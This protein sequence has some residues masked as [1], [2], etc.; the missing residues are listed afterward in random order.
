MGKGHKVLETGEIKYTPSVPELNFEAFLDWSY[1][2]FM[3]PSCFFKAKAWKECGPLREDLYFCL[4]V[5]LW[6]KMSQKYRFAKIEDSL[7]HAIIHPDAK[8]TAETER[9]IV[10]TS[11]LVIQ[12]GATDI[13]RKNLMKLADQNYKLKNENKTLKSRTLKGIL[14]KVKNKLLF[15]LKLMKK[16]FNL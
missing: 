3:Q 11:L 10:E 15:L 1:S 7:S 2:H 6:L 14:S 5:D 12:Y 13:A 8:T 9:M 16:S 4:D